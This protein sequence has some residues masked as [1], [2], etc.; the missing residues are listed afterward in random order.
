M[1]NEER[2]KWCLSIINEYIEKEFK[3]NSNYKYLSNE[4]QNLL[5]NGFKKSTKTKMNK[6]FEIMNS[7]NDSEIF[8]FYGPILKGCYEDYLHKEKIKKLRKKMSKNN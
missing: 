2:T 4:I 7:N 1:N 3:D 5:L 8:D 6:I